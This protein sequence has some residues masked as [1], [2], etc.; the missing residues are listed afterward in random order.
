[1]QYGPVMTAI[2]VYLYVGQL[3]SKQRTAQALADLFGVPITDATVAAATTRAAAGL[4]PFLTQVRD[5]IARADV[6][7]FDETG[8][9]IASKLGWIHS[10]S[11]AAL[12]LLTAHRR[13]GVEAMNDAGVLPGF[14]GVCPTLSR[15]DAAA[16][17][18]AAL[19][20]T[21]GRNARELRFSERSA[22]GRIRGISAGQGRRLRDSNP[23]RAVNPNR[24][25]RALRLLLPSPHRTVSYP[26]VQVLE[27]FHAD[28]CCA[29]T[30]GSSP[31]RLTLDSPA[32]P[33]TS[34]SGAGKTRRPDLS[35]QRNT[36]A[37][38]SV[39]FPAPIPGT[40][41]YLRCPRRRGPARARHH[42]PACVPS[43][44]RQRDRSR[45]IPASCEPSGHTAGGQPDGE[46]A[47]HRSGTH[48]TG[49][50]RLGS[51][52]TGSRVPDRTR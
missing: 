13:R 50:T 34:A 44:S 18:R 49:Q 20:Q 47:D 35:S 5:G 40:G 48:P 12:S 6:A 42:R 19:V 29:A 11:T 7:H 52:A 33:A 32:R 8:F 51:R 27:P 41:G 24:I 1:M 30:A 28:Q 10:A 39:D 22:A 46:G 3:L 4:A 2:I 9:R 31:S 45:P 21:G 26:F 16:P 25:S 17:T 37:V 23:G 36:R 43:R 38:R 15:R 14:T